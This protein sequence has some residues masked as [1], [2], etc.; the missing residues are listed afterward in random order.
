MKCDRR[1][2]KFVGDE[3]RKYC[4][5]AQLALAPISKDHEQGKKLVRFFGDW[6]MR[7]YSGLDLVPEYSN[8]SF[9]RYFD[10]SAAIDQYI[11]NPNYGSGEM[12]KIAFA[13]LFGDGKDN[14]D[15]VYTLRANSTNFNVPENA[16]RPAQLTHP[17]TRRIFDDFAASDKACAPA[18]G[19][20]A[21]GN[22][23]ESCTGQYI[24]NGAITMQRLIGDFIHNITF[25]KARGF[26]IA[27]H[28]VS[29]I[30]F[31]TK[32]YSVDGFYKTVNRKFNSVPNSIHT[33]F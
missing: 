11:R 14:F 20:A 33:N 5:Y 12:R 29:F 28:G 2:C 3:A 6:V 26:Y 25:S 18:P 21:Q 23:S 1:T 17:P 16:G 19:T 9:I 13:I 24:Y 31:P 27:E 4:E 30:N 10:D 8:N 22:F 32:A 7:E 15:F